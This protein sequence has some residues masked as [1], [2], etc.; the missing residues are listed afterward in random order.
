LRFKSLFRRPVGAQSLIKEVNRAE[1]SVKLD[2]P[3]IK[4]AVNRACAERVDFAKMDAGNIH[5]TLNEVFMARES[6]VIERVRKEKRQRVDVRR[7]TKGLT[8]TEDLSSLS[9]VTE[10][11]PNGGVK[12][13]E[14]MAAVFG[15]TETEMT[16]LGS[17]VR[18]LRLYSEDQ[19]GDPASWTP[20]IAAALMS[21]QGD[22]LR[23]TSGHS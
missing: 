14:V 5:R 21:E 19:T 16:S 12:P 2:A 7:Y 11:S 1:Y 23:V 15:L 8:I 10:V 13:V 3:E 22:K 20:G 9:I 18:R 6:C 4:A 17:R